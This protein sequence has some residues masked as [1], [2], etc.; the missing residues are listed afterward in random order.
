MVCGGCFSFLQG[1]EPKFSVDAVSTQFLRGVTD[2]AANFERGLSAPATFDGDEFAQLLDFLA[3]L[4]LFKTQLPRAELPIVAGALQRKVWSPGDIV[5]EQGKVGKALFIIAAGEASVVSK[6][7]LSGETTVLSTLFEQDYF[8]NSALTENRPNVATIVAKSELVTF[9]LTRDKFERLGLH[10]KL[11]FPRRPAVYEGVRLRDRAISECAGTS[12]S[13][14]EG[15]TPQDRKGCSLMA[16]QEISTQDRNFICRA[17]ETNPNCRARGDGGRERLE[18]LASQARR[19]QVQAGCELVRGGA[20]ADELYVI[21]RGNFDVIP[22]TLGDNQLRSAEAKLASATVADRFLKREE[23]LIDLL[24]READRAL[25]RGPS[26]TEGSSLDQLEISEWYRRSS[27]PAEVQTL[28]PR[29]IELLGG[30]TPKAS[31]DGSSTGEGIVSD[32]E[33][34]NVVSPI[35]MNQKQR[36]PSVRSNGNLASLHVRQRSKTVEAEPQPPR[37]SGSRRPSAADV[38]LY[39]V[40][41]SVALAR[42]GAEGRLA[43]WRVVQVM[44]PGPLGSVLVELEGAEPLRQVVATQQ[45]RPAM[46][47]TPIGTLHEGNCFGELALLYNCSQ[48]ATVRATEDSIVYSMS[49][50]Q[51]KDCFS[52]D[53]PHLAKYCRLLDEVPK[54]SRL[55]RSVRSEVARNARGLIRFKPNQIVMR[56]G[57]VPAEPL[58]YIVAEG[59]GELVTVADSEDSTLCNNADYEA[60]AAR[61]RLRRGSDFGEEGLLRQSAGCTVTAGPEGMVCLVIRAE[62]LNS[63]KVHV[64]GQEEGVQLLGLLSEPM[65]FMRQ[66]TPVMWPELH[67][68]QTTAVVGEGG[69]GAVFLV[70]NGASGEEGADERSDSKEVFALKRISK[71]FVVKSQAQKQ[72]AQERD[73]LSL[74]VDSP[75]II[76]FLYSY[77]DAEFVYLLMEV[78][79]GGHLR[80]LLQEKPKLFK[81]D[82]P[83][84]STAKFFVAC[85]IT[86]LEYLHTRHIV[87]RDLKTENLVLDSDGYCKLIDVGF[88][89]FVMGKTYTVVGTVEYMAPEMCEAPHAHGLAVDWWAIGVLTFELLTGQP[90]W[91]VPDFDS[92]LA[93]RWLR[94]RQDKGLPDSPHLRLPAVD[95]SA[96]C[97]STASTL[98]AAKDFIQKLCTVH[99]KDRLGYTKGAAELRRHGWFY[100]FDFNALTTKTLPSPYRPSG[101]AVERDLDEVGSPGDDYEGYL[102]D[103]LFVPYH[104]EQDSLAGRWLEVF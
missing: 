53:T 15:H 68:W 58:W 95:C 24:T 56:Q 7:D 63:L 19:W 98:P 50:R 38:N 3:S 99:V 102:D 92:M 2:A 57:D 71:G 96:F 64:D 88:A 45:L 17:L 33:L 37:S 23:F 70:R 100:K 94:A 6:D 47:A 73:I 86:A 42:S 69:F 28:T 11:K 1:V 12:G 34:S 39:A 90:P 67:E 81:R 61:K 65:T 87:Y 48:V 10:Q 74:L 75:F 84:G 83:R 76:R 91:D 14:G 54:L 26:T 41:T 20:P 31:A 80:G 79:G 85:A 25:S 78:A 35:C 66:L 32:D 27:M 16:N 40:G 46:E 101:I 77:Q 49:R 89:R 30:S 52:F 59:T 97:P 18:K 93:L 72:I 13:P 55:L 62:V 104:R 4:P 8:G 82:F 36:R 9:C 60:A 103:A 5:V 44:E 43:T 51:F 21:A 22:H 29:K